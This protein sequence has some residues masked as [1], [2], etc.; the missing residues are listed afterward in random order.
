MVKNN[1]LVYNPVMSKVE[2]IRKYAWIEFFI[3]F[4]I[5]CFCVASIRIYRHYQYKKMDSYQ[6]FLPDADGLIVGSP[7]RYMGVQVGYISK[8]KILSSEVYIKFLITDKD[9]ELPK[10]SI[11]TVEFSGMG[12]SKSLEIYP[13]TSESIAT[14]KIIVVSNP[15]R[16]SDSLS[17]LSQMF[18][19]IN[20]IIIRTGVFANETGM[21]DIKQ[22]IDTKGIERNMNAADEIMKK[23]RRD[24]NEQ[25]EDNK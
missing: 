11:V 22:G 1:K 13:P 20:S 8:I 25:S 16:L 24:N 15:V 18:D 21:F 3:W 2:D 7:V 6:I 4:L 17:L 14:G 19:K 5:L 12:G 10:G 23:L 9:L